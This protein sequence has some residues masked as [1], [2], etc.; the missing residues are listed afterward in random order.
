MSLVLLVSPREN[1][2]PPLALI[3]VP[4]DP[5]AVGHLH[6]LGAFGGGVYKYNYL[7]Q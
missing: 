1:F 5:K 3:A 6:S 2:P 7:M 4:E